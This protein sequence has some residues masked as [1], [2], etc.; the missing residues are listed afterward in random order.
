LYS[1]KCIYFYI[2]HIRKTVKYWIRSRKFSKKLESVRKIQKLSQQEAVKVVKNGVN[3]LLFHWLLYLFFA[4]SLYPTLPKN[5]DLYQFFKVKCH[6]LPIL[7]LSPKA[8]NWRTLTTLG[9]RRNKQFCNRI[10]VYSSCSV[11][12]LPD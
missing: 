2:F 3:L 5:V 6:F 1:C 10:T 8:V 12:T 7:L 9:T 11:L 4:D